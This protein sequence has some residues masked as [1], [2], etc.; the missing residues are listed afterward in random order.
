[1]KL[2]EYQAKAVFDAYGIPTMKGIVLDNQEDVAA[3][4][5]AA[6]L[7]YP[8]VLKAQVQIGGR[9]KAGGIQFAEDGK[10]A[11]EIVD[12][13]LFSDLKGFR[14]KELLCVEKCSL[15]TEWYLSI[16][17]DRGAKC[18]LIM[19]SP[20]GGM[21]IEEVAQNSPQSILKL[22]VDPLLGITAD[23]V[24]YLCSKSG[25][26]L[27]FEK[28]LGDVLTKLYTAFLE[29]SCLLLE[30]N[31]LCVA[32]EG[33]LIAL[34]GKVDIDDSALFRLPDVTA[35]RGAQQEDPLIKE[36]RT[37]DFLYIPVGEEGDAAVMSNGSGMLMSCIDLMAKAGIATTAALDL[38]G[39]ATAV[40]IREAVRIVLSN[41]RVK[42]LFICIFGGIT[43]CDEVAEGVRMALSESRDEKQVVIRMEGTNKQKGLEIVEATRGAL[44]VGGI[45]EG[46]RVL[47]EGRVQR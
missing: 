17:L 31:P 18:P 32:E 6:G 29:Y 14:V 7:N 30:I 25:I 12:R 2:L 22:P 28:K 35:W 41:P 5:A 24:R 13:L 16:L 15:T 46:V 27:A 26:G 20:Q 43:R 3:K 1:M 21:D 38:G 33:G 37:F 4:I 40:R 47:A 44:H 45:V 36:A 11:Q 39:G 10:Q 42:T 8:V 34:D 23:T 9:G 19:F